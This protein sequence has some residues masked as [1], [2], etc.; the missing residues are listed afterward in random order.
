MPNHIWY[1]FKWILDSDAKFWR[2][3]YLVI[4]GAGG[5]MLTFYELMIYFRIPFSCSESS[6][7][8]IV[9]KRS[10]ILQSKK[11]LFFPSSKNA[12]VLAIAVH[13]LFLNTKFWFL[14]L[15]KTNPLIV[16]E[17]LKELTYSN[18]RNSS[19]TPLKIQPNQAQKT[20]IQLRLLIM[21][22]S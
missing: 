16:K 2:L 19:N 13:T 21:M 9:E 14:P 22:G 8:M 11:Y 3:R 20:R 17:L 12:S 15:E 7:C 10:Q 6:V 5:S 4:A 18:D 1:M